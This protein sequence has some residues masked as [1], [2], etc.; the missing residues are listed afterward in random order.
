MR[1]LLRTF[2]QYYRTLGPKGIVYLL[3]AY[4]FPSS[5]MRQIYHPDIKHSFYL[6]I[7]SADVL[8]YRQIFV[9]EEYAFEPS[10]TPRSIIDA[11][12]NIGLATLYFA[13][14]FPDASIISVE[15]EGHNYR[16]LEKNVSAYPQIKTVQAAIWK[17]NEEISVIDPGL[18]EWGYQTAAGEGLLT[19]PSRHAV[20]GLTIDRL[21]A[22]HGIDFVDILKIDIEGAEKEVFENPFLWID[23]VGVL[24]IELHEHLKIGCNRN[25]YNATNH[26]SSEWLQ[27]ENVFLT[28]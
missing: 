11:G 7:G 21:M 3:Q 9:D 24:I 25:F 14:R 27:G 2:Q 18:G 12:A 4:A 22:D 28:R 10:R 17:D 20:Q 19:S 6:R 15:P 1:H 8:T 26:F 5:A 13:N 23:R 16:L